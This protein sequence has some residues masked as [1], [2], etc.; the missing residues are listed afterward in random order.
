MSC[1]LFLRQ[2]LF[3]QDFATHLLQIPPSRCTTAVAM[4][5]SRRGWAGNSRRDD[6][7]RDHW[8]EFDEFLQKK[9][10]KLMDFKADND[11]LRSEVQ[12]LRAEL[13]RKDADSERQTKRAKAA[14]ESVFAVLAASE[15]NEDT[16][17]TCEQGDGAAAGGEDQL[18]PSLP[19]DK[20]TAST[21]PGEAAPG[22]EEEE[23]EEEA[24]MQD[25]ALEQAAHSTRM[26][27]PE[28]PQALGGQ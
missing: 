23:Q 26:E 25:E 12:R 14:L 9:K 22:R 6:R 3:R 18:R 10:R 5:R 8:D 19:K 27:I 1:V 28:M 17:S 15:K 11:R 4:D 16:D 24:K 2:S 13:D 20:D 7:K 21:G